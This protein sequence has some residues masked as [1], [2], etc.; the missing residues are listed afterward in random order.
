MQGKM[1]SVW[2]ISTIGGTAAGAFLFGLA[3]DSFPAT[4]VFVFAIFIGVA[5]IMACGYF[6]RARPTNGGTNSPE[7]P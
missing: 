7:S 6:V 3:L 4:R 1:A 2:S 5:A